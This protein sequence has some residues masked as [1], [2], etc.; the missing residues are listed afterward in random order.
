MN[1]TPPWGRVFARVNLWTERV[2]S[3][4][5]HLFYTIP[6]NLLP[7][8]RPHRETLS[9]SRARLCF[10]D[11]EA[12]NRFKML[13]G[14]LAILSG[15]TVCILQDVRSAEGFGGREGTSFC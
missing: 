2:A 14:F 10:R 6:S 12:R 1:L 4:T 8:Q 3:S 7:G 15:L 9:R 5:Q 13:P 11:A